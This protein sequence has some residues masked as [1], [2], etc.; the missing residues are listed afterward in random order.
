MKY[1]MDILPQILRPT[2]DS[3]RYLGRLT[4]FAVTVILVGAIVVALFAFDAMTRV[5]S[6]CAL[7]QDSQDNLPTEFTYEDRDLQEY[8]MDTYE[9]V[10]FVSRGD[11]VDLSGWYIPVDNSAKVILIVHGVQACKQVSFTLM[12]AG[13]LHRAGYNVLV[14]DL[15][16]HGE[17]EVTNGRHSAGNQEYR[18]VLGAWDWLVE[19][20]GFAPTS[21]GVVGFSLG[22][23]SSIIATAEEPEL[24]AVWSDSSFT[25]VE[26]VGQDIASRMGI[27]RVAGPL[28]LRLGQMLYRIDLTSKS[29]DEAIQGLDGRPIFLVQGAADGLLTVDHAEKLGAEVDVTPWFVDDAPHV[30]SIWYATDEYERLLLA[31]FDTALEPTE[32]FE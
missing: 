2:K 8:F 28:A 16:N 19:E 24:A 21:I 3:I 13:M 11:D 29:P 17:S 9:T 31:F 6:G 14:I 32:A 20:R 25:S 12:S 27:P 7:E 15:R 5:E 30:E 4:V 1:L 26:D 23:A 10:S 18:D 22:A